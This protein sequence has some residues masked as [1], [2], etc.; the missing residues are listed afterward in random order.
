MR[1][2]SQN[3]LHDRELVNRLIRDSSIS[4]SDTV[5]DIGACTGIITRELATIAKLVIA[6]EIDPRLASCLQHMQ[7]VQV[8]CLS[9]LD[10]PLPS[11]PYKVFSNPPFSITGDVIRK[12]LQSIHPPQ[13]SYLVLQ[14]EAAAKFIIHANCNT[15]AAILYYPWWDISIT[16]SFKKADFSP[17]PKVNS[18]L[19]HI[20]SQMTPLIPTNH[21]DLYQDFVAYH[22]A[23]DRFAKFAPAPDWIPLFNHFLDDPQ[24]IRSI[25]GSFTKLQRQQHSLEKIHR[26]R[27]DKNWRNFK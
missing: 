12:L 16:H 6:I 2:Y 23:H 26:T 8:Q 13:D 22:Y 5:L 19:L 20:Q 27:T 21:Q 1:L 9:I 7:K 25:R 10:Y 3:F 15:M 18:V 4:P 24:L 17:P 14:S 11:T